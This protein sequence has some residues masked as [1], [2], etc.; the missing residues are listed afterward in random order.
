MTKLPSDSVMIKNFHLGVT[1]KELAE[2]YEVTIQAVSK[3]MVKLGLRRKPIAE[4]VSAGINARWG[5]IETH[6]YGKSHHKAW[7]GKML[8]AYL[9]SRL[10]DEQLRRYQVEE[11]SAW[12]GSMADRVLG[13]NPDVPEGWYYRPR[14]PRDGRLVVDWPT[15]IPFPDEEFRRALELPDT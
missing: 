4:R 8:R 14:E 5:R 10:G 6:R 1:D 11:A 13:Y 7:P 12:V 9:R 2:Q 3:R 15:E